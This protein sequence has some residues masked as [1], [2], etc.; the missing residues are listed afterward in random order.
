VSWELNASYLGSIDRS[1]D[2]RP[3]DT[4]PSTVHQASLADYSGSG[5]QRGH[6]CPSGDRTKTTTANQ[7]TFYLSNMVPQASNNNTGPWEKLESYA[8]TLAATKELFVISGGIYSGTAKTIGS[9]VAVP[10]DTFKV[11]VVLD[12]VGDGPSDVTDSTR[13]IAVVMP[14][15]NSQISTSDS[16][17]EYRVSVRSIESATGFDFLSDVDPAVQDVVETRVDTQ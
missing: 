10:S 1:D 17:Q 11:I 12:H 3:D 16:W 2:Y 14:N 15:D 13:V 8:R 4:L 5:W 9:G 6:M 7:Q